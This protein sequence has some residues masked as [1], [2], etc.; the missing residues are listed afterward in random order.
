M[1]ERYT[2]EMADAYLREKTQ[3]EAAE[4]RERRER[5]EKRS[6]KKAWTEDGGAEDDFERRWA[7]IRDEAR[8]RRIADADRRAREAQRASGLGRI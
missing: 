1:S 4:E 2:A 3:R 8:A 7:G 5:A 6:A